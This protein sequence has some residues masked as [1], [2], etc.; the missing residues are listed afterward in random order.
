[1]KYWDNKYLDDKFIWGSEISE[2]IIVRF[3][4]MSTSLHSKC[5]AET[6]QADGE[7]VRVRKTWRRFWNYEEEFE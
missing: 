4:K 6:N 5:E 2:D 7:L 1:M 3:L